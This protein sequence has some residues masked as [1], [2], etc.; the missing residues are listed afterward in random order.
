M[1]TRTAPLSLLLIAYT[2]F[3]VMALPTGIL[4]VAWTYMQTDFTLTLNSLGVILLAVTGGRLIGTFFS[5]RVI[6][7]FGVGAF[8]TAGGAT[9][10]L[11]LLGYVLSPS[12]VTLIAAAFVTA[13]GLSTFDAGLNT[14]VSANYTTGQLNWLHAAYALG[15]TAGP[16]LITLIVE[17]YGQS[18]HLGYA[19]VLGAI[20]LLLAVLIVTR[21]RWLMPQAE[22]DPSPRAE[23]PRNAPSPR[24]SLML[25]AVLLGMGLFFIFNG[26]VAGTG[27]LSKTL[28][29]ARGVEQ[30]GFWISFYWGFFFLG[31]LIMGFVAYR[32]NNVTLIRVC[33]IGMAIG[34]TLLWQSASD[35][36]NLI[37]LALIGLS[38]APLFPTLIAETPGRVGVRHRANA[39]GFQISAAALGSAILPGIM[40][41]LAQRVGVGVIGAFP[42]VGIAAVAALHEFAVR[43]RA[44]VPEP[45]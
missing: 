3:F 36:L 20:L 32:L 38:S 21:R 8:L 26:V 25:P 5:G 15:M 23:Q 34:A 17:R 9:A 35:T 6:G 18:W 33:F 43:R 12:W 13:L 16:T 37:G 39:I 41:A 7:R 1:K 42:L 19:V 40:G 24:A 31:R 10:A 28:L 4:N 2:L 11:G 29:T 27:Q 30:A 45:A 22:R 14:F 44:A